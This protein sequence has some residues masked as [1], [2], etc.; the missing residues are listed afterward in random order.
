MNKTITIILIA[1][2]A[3]VATDY[4]DTCTAAV[5]KYDSGTIIPDTS[6]LIFYGNSG[7]D[8]Y[9]FVQRIEINITGNKRKLNI[10]EYLDSAFGNKTRT[11]SLQN[12]SCLNCN[13]IQEILRTIDHSNFDSLKCVS[14]YSSAVSGGWGYCFYC[15]FG[16][17]I[18]SIGILDMDNSITIKEYVMLK[19]IFNNKNLFKFSKNELKK[20]YQRH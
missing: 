13:K 6:V 9:G 7:D 8:I 14:D 11:T 20:K 2:S 18:H 5:V 12:D 16:K 19:E 3:A 10:M 4:Y 17:K 1:I 15:K